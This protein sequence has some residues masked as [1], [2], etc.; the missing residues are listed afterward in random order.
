MKGVIKVIIAVMGALLFIYGAAGAGSGKP[1]A[2][3]EAYFDTATGHKYI[4]NSDTTYSEFSKKGRLIRKDVPNSLPLLVSNK[5]IVEVQRTHFIVY[6][7]SRGK[8][9]RQKILPATERHPIGWKS[10]Q[11]M[12]PIAANGEAEAYTPPE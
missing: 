9:L 4:K 12:S 7:K 8:N 6:E 3:E 5:N 2:V 10:V 11:V 1:T